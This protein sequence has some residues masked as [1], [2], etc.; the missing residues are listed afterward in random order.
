[1]NIE[2]RMSIEIREVSDEK[3]VFELNGCDVSVAN[4]LRRIMISEVPVIAI[5]FVNIYENTS[6]MCDEFLAHRVG[7]IPL[8]SSNVEK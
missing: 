3:I 5:D 6:V 8:N 1:M 7:L 2:P 4:A